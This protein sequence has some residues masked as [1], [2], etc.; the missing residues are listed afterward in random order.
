MVD[1]KKLESC[2]QSLGLQK[3]QRHIF[4][5]ADQTKPK[6]C[7]KEVGLESWDYLKRR[8]GELGLDEPGGD[9]E[10]CIFRTK[11]NCLRVCS[12]G[13]ILLVYPDGIWYR[14]ATPEIIER[15]IQEHLIGDR[16]VEEYIFCH[17]PL[18]ENLAAKTS[19]ANNP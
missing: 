7:P 18:T 11:T 8:L 15:I 12:E 4:L 17:H 1:T 16:P 5:C 13:P 19:S 14:H 9:R 3:I 6:C 10:T 2:V